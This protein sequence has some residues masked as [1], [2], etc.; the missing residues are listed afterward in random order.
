MRP[1]AVH[2]ACEEPGGVLARDREGLGSRL[3]IVGP[4][5]AG[6]A[7]ALR[8]RVRGDQRRQLLSMQTLSISMVI[9]GR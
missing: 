8:D 9:P 6:P 2:L 3:A 7:L 5:A 4:V 1:Q